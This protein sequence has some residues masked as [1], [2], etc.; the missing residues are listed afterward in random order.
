MEGVDTYA[1]VYLNGNLV[2]KTNDFYLPYVFDV[3][4][5]IKE[6]N[7]L[8]L[9]FH[10]IN[11]ELKKHPF[12]EEW[13][14]TILPCKV[15]RKPIH[16]FPS[17][18]TSSGSNY[19][20]AV[21]FFQPIGIYGKVRIEYADTARFLS[22]HIAA[23]IQAPYEK[24]R[25]NLKVSGKNGNILYFE[26]LDKNGTVVAEKQILV[27]GNWEKDAFLEIPYPR[28]WYPRGFGKQER[29]TVRLRLWENGE[30]KD[31]IEKR[32]GF[33]EVVTDGNLNFWINGYLVRLYGGSTDPFQGYSH[34]FDSKRVN[35]VLD[36]VENA[37][38]NCL[39]LWGEGIPYDDELYEEADRRGI[40]IWQEFFM[41][42]GA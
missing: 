31:R 38:M 11:G 17:A 2:G 5:F 40:L 27:E 25:V 13:G 24:G 32:I 28:L 26:V 36:M 14:E 6:E 3:T 23:I 4:P 10:N 30:E 12:L 18:N 33:K 8:L 42:H 21:K 7:V 35:R 16:D 29:Y 39:R 1:D 34:C 22:E 9:H 15:V 37:H 20:G 19:Q 41:G